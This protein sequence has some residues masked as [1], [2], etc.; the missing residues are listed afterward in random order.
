[1][2]VD[3]DKL[4]R[5][6]EKTLLRDDVPE[7]EPG[8]TVRVHIRIYEETP[9]LLHLKKIH[10]IAARGKEQ[11]QAKVER[12]QVFE[13]V[14]LAV[15]G[16][17]LGRSITVRKISNGVGVEKVFPLHSRRIEKIEVLRHAK[18]RR[19]KLYYLRNR[20]GKAA[21]LKERR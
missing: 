21:R 12:V 20:V 19:A 6:Y 15:D 13:G 2:A 3:L 9:E 5:D 10:R 14:V 17:G 16:Q 18:V 8:D 4:V 7:I 11:K 1:M